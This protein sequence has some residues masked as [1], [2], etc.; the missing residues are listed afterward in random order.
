MS[1]TGEGGNEQREKRKRKE[2]KK[3][4][5]RKRE[6]GEVETAAVAAASEERKKKSDQKRRLRLFFIDWARL[7]EQ[8][9]FQTV[10]KRREEAQSDS[11]RAF[12]ALAKGRK[13]RRRKRG[14]E[15]EK[16]ALS[17]SQ[18]AAAFAV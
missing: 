3:E 11:S 4:R 2:K 15:I 12:R 17:L 7:F 9:G 16:K 1:E 18:A 14:G 5:K 13:G 10:L 8:Q 6:R